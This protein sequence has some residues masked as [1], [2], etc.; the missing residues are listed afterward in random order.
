MKGDFIM[1]VNEIISN[2]E[3]LK[4]DILLD[5]N[6]TSN[7]EINERI[8]FCNYMIGYLETVGL[9]EGYWQ[10]IDNFDK[11]SVNN[12]A[13]ESQRRQI[14]DTIHYN[15]YQSNSV[16]ENKNYAD[17]LM[18]AE[19]YCQIK[20]LRE[21]LEQIKLLELKTQE[22]K[23]PQQDSLDRSLTQLKIKEA[24]AKIEAFEI[25]TDEELTEDLERATQL[26]K[27]E[28][29]SEN[30]ERDCISTCETALAYVYTKELEKQLNNLQRENFSELPPSLQKDI[31]AKKH[32]ITYA[33]SQKQEVEHS[34]T[35]IKALAT[36]DF[37]KK[38]D[39]PNAINKTHE[40]IEKIGII[41]AQEAPRAANKS[42]Q[43]QRHVQS[44]SIGLER[45]LDSRR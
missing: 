21:E 31:L 22:E 41:K 33:L 23:E 5:H 44:K 6:G 28:T 32:E 4:D 25:A 18:T 40:V 39:L 16:P 37:F 30:E 20:A 13:T 15:S 43:V 19:T 38:M 24:L 17:Y 10:N 11:L 14:Y 29:L 26:T 7:H 45:E 3:D 8:N 27:T 35:A 42:L 12:I 34:F 1:N 9:E 36:L 2:F